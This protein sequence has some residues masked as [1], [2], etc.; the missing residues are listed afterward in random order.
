MI[1]LLTRWTWSCCVSLRPRESLQ[2]NRRIAVVLVAVSLAAPGAAAGQEGQD[3]ATPPDAVTPPRPPEEPAREGGVE[4]TARTIQYT[5]AK[6]P[7]TGLGEYPGFEDKKIRLP[8][9]LEDAVA[10]AI[11]N[12]L[13]VE[14][15]SYNRDIARRRVTIERAVFDPFFN[16]SFTYADNREPTVSTLDFDPLNPVL[17]VRV[18]PFDVTTFRSGIRGTTLLGTSYQVSVVESRFNSPEASASLFAL[19]PRYS[20]RAEFTLTQPLLRGGWYDT[21]AANIRIAR[22]SLRISESQYK[23]TQIESVFNVISAYWDL[24]FAHKNYDAKASA[25]KVAIDQ[26][27]IDRQREQVGAIA[28][29]DLINPES[30]LA[31]RKTEFEQAITVFENTRDNIL[32]L[33]NYTG[34]DS[35]KTL[36]A[37]RDEKSPFENILIIP[38]TPPVTDLMVYDRDESLRKAFEFREEYRRIELQIRSQDIVVD[39]ARNRVLPAL[40]ITGTWAQL[41]LDDEFAGSTDSVGRG[42]FYDWQAGVVLELPLAYRGPISELRNAEDERRK[43]GLQK[44]SLENLIVVE[45]DQAIRDVRE[46]YRTVQN[47]HHEVELQVAL[48][49]A[50]KAK[51]RVGRSIAYTVSQIENDLVDIQAQANRAETNFEKFKSAYERSVGTLLEKYGIVFTNGPE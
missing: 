1:S 20:S 30:Q 35:L 34:K 12:N 45:V 5:P 16:L 51:L 17:G 18:N 27:R 25:L 43:L 10:I 19:N 28:K 47:L 2:P 33:M 9:S 49:E 7:E 37:A 11:R 24:V 13:D 39:V 44:Q 14:V 8:L 40:D 6:L 21:N 42:H 29:I 26:L 41:G 48:L 46:S 15:E 31:R 23:L 22:N 32:V 36:W 4:R 50:E 3:Q 38:T